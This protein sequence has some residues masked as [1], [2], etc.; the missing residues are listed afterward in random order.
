L[1]RFNDYV[2]EKILLSPKKQFGDESASVYFV[3]L[4]GSEPGGLWIE[5]EAL[6]KMVLVAI[7]KPDAKP[8]KKVVF[9]L[10]YSEIDYAVSFSTDLDEKILGL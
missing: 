1:V 10:P 3:T 7:G 4:Q 5:Y 6:T 2:G 9:F 8:P